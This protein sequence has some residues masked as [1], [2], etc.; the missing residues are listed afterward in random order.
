LQLPRLPPDG[1][2][3]VLGKLGAQFLVFAIY[4]SSFY[5]IFQWIYFNNINYT[6]D[7]RPT[8][9]LQALFREPNLE[10]C[11]TCLPPC[12]FFMQ[13]LPVAVL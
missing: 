6:I 1:F 3:V 2:P 12:N 7:L 9:H 5:I 10:Y 11:M 4:I 8:L 13:S